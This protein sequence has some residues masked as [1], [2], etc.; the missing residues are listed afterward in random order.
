MF[1]THA[2]QSGSKE[3]EYRGA[4]IKDESR[5]GGKNHKIEATLYLSLKLPQNS[6]I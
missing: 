3:E 6:K 4:R 2:F 1:R 5:V